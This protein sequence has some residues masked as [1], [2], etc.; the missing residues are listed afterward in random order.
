MPLHVWKSRRRL[1][2]Q[3]MNGFVGCGV[4]VYADGFV[5]VWIGKKEEEERVRGYVPTTISC[6][7]ADDVITS[8]ERGIKLK[9]NWG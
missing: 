5:D 7:I 4:C 6:M 9:K 2:T 3:R 8:K 1:P